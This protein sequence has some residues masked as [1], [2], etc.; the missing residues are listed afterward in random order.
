M[1]QHLLDEPQQLLGHRRLLLR[2]LRKVAHLC[3]HVEEGEAAL[4]RGRLA[5]TPLDLEAARALELPLDPI[6]RALE[7]LESGLEELIRAEDEH[8]VHRVALVERVVRVRLDGQLDVGEVREDA[9]V[10]L[11]RHVLRLQRFHVV[12]QHALHDRLL[13]VE[14]QVVFEFGWHGCLV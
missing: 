12:Q 14:L 1:Q 9:K 5:V 13:P 8:Q 4:D 3:E 6:K 2:L 7:R 10:Q 11:I